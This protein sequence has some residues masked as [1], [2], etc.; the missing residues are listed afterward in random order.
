MD[1][2]SI[3]TQ[4]ANIKTTEL[5]LGDY[6]YISHMELF[7]GRGIEFIRII[8]SKE[9]ILEIGN[10]RSLPKCKQHTFDIGSHEKP[11]SILGVIENRKAGN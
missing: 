1:S 7:C 11:I 4:Y 2:F 3:P 8:T 6:E 9:H 10:P 5:I